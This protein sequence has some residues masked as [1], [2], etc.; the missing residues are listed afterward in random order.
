M[1]L[2]LFLGACGKGANKKIEKK[3]ASGP[4]DPV[5]API[6]LPATLGVEKIARFNYVYDSGKASYDKAEAAAKKK[7]W[8]EARKLAEASLLKDPNHMD[9]HRVLAVALA[10]LGEHAAA[11]DHLVGIIGADYYNY[12]VSFSTDPL[13]EGFRA[14]P[15]GKAV[16]Q[17][18]NQIRDEYTAKISKAL[19]FIARRS[20]FR[21]DKYGPQFL[22]SRG[23]LYAFDRDTKRYFR[24]THT[25]HQVT[26]FVRAK[27]GSEVAVLGYDKADRPKD[28]DSPPL[29]VRGW[30]QTFDTAEWKSTSKVTL[31]QSRAYTIYYGDGDQ[32]LVAQAPAAD[33]WTLG[34]WVI[35]SVDRTTGKLTKTT[36]T[37]GAPRIELTLD[38]GQIV[39]PATND[40]VQAVWTGTPARAPELTIGSTKI[41]IPE[42]GQAAQETIA[43]APGGGWLAFATAVDPCAKDAAPSLYV[44]NAKTGALKHLLTAKSRF[45]TRWL[46][47]NTLAYEDGDSAIRLWDATTGREAMRIENKPGVGLAVLSLASAPLCKQAPPSAEPTGSAG[48]GD[49]MPPEEGSGPVTSPQ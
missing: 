12:G 14:T 46:D 16:S 32:L 39:L 43:V 2:F 31:G 45:A 19:L 44:A 1:V 42:S 38:E 11:V 48:S 21:Y 17:L 25:G 36:G 3:D 5:A 37:L 49:E 33:R 6:A 29:L 30:V 13:L 35:S 18:A 23:E 4:T 47:A 24:L 26:G 28:N 34:E 27:S 41:A 20:A 9:A 7:D 15:H 10:Q 8:A 22:S 40:G